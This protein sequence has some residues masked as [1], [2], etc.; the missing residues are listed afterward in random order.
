MAPKLEFLTI[1]AW[2]VY[3]G[4]KAA[5]VVST[6]KT[7]IKNHHPAVFALMEASNLYGQLDALGYKVVQLKPK[8]RR[9]GNQPAQ[10][11][12]AILISPEYAIKERKSLRMLTFWKGPKHGWPQDPRVYRYVKIR[13]KKDPTARTWK[14]C[15]AHTPFGMAARL[16]SRKRLVEW[17]RG[18]S[19]KQPTIL[20]LDAN[21]TLKHFREVIAKPGGAQSSGIGID[22]EAHKNCTLV[23]TEN[24]GLKVSDHPA[25][26][27]KY[28]AERR[29]V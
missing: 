16:E 9:K 24:L 1:I 23:Q 5:V 18:S 14:I 20:V 19:P 10:G 27:R 28:S 12:I 25:I 11:N 8:P 17:L 2:N 21:M 22:L 13:K 4:N 29:V 26:K 6:L 15:A 7:M 3:V